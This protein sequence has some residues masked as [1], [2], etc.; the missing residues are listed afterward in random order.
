MM[1]VCIRWVS[2][3]DIGIGGL[4]LHPLAEV[5]VMVL[6]SKC[7]SLTRNPFSFPVISVGLSPVS[8]LIAIF[9][10]RVPFA[11]DMSIKHFSSDGG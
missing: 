6:V 5:G 4:A 11:F 7:M 9:R 3:N 10:D 8:M 1:C 2:S